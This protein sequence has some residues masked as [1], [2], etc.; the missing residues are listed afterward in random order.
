MKTTQLLS[1]LFISFLFHSC[2]FGSKNE[3]ILAD[4]QGVASIVLS[5]QSDELIKWAAT[6]LAGDL[7]SLSGQKPR[8]LIT[9]QLPEG[10]NRIII[11]GKAGD[12]LLTKNAAA[13]LEQVNG[14]WEKFMI[15]A[16]GQRLYIVGS[17]VRGTVYGIFDLAE[18]LGIS[19]WSWWADVFP[20]PGNKVSLSLPEGGIV[21]EPSVQ[22]RGIFLNDEDWGLH[23]WAAQTF[24]PETGDIGPKSYEKI[25][26]LLLR[27]KANII[28]PAMHPCTKAFYT[29]EGN[30]EMAQKYHMV[31]GTSHAEPMLRNNV[32]EWKHKERGAF[33]YFEN[34]EAVEE[35]WRERIKQVAG[36]DHRFMVTVGMR[37][38]H[39]GKMEGNATTDE[40]VAMLETI[41][42]KQRQMLEEELG[43]SASEVPQ[44]LVPYK[45][46]LDLYNAGL[47]VPDDVTLIWTDDNYGYIRRRSD[48][49]EQRRP[50]GSGVYYH[51]SYWGRPHDYLWLSTTQPALIWYEMKRAWENGAQK[52][53]IGNVGDIKPAE[54]NMEFFL[55]L[56]W[57]IDVVNHNNIDVHLKNWAA[58]EF[59]E[60]LADDIAALKQEYYRLAMLRKPEFMGWSRTEPSTATQQGEFSTR[61]INDL[62]IRLSQYHRLYQQADALKEKVAPRLRDAYFQLVEYPVKGAALMN[63]K[64]LYA[65]LAY[66]ATDKV[67]KSRYDSLARKAYAEIETLT[68][69]YNNEMSQGKWKH[70]MSSKPR[71]LAA[72]QMP[73]YHL[74][75]SASVNEK[76]E[77]AASSQ[78]IQ[79]GDYVTATGFEQYKW[80]KI[81]GLGYSAQAL[82]L[83]PLTDRSFETMQP[84]VTYRFTIDEPGA[85]ELELRCLPTHANNFDHQLSIAVENN[86]EQTFKLNTRGRSE[87]WKQN[88]LRNHSRIFYPMNFDSAGEKEVR[89]SVNQTGIVIDQLAVRLAGSERQ[90]MLPLK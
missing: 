58:R 66:E 46:V 6:E 16:V 29:I 11:I 76:V 67:S 12:E 14:A 68:N 61:G 21:Q 1:I 49:K 17:D 23:P 85:Y 36:G 73:D 42:D 47:N 9:D 32:D 89:L 45:E 13:E 38:V 26:Q 88:V 81:Q 71:K 4:K 10:E 72:Y 31:I 65:Q 33:N 43:L 59:G 34:S 35:Y 90:Y 69:Y 7:E 25:F 83:L 41:F 19:P 3:L 18:Q 62:E 50:G 24:E 52:V 79:A 60:K 30:M 86:Q 54:Y 5:P 57:N 74:E 80:K 78:F 37:G 20:E 75:Q 22:Y 51:L 84:S 48:A 56:A 82:T 28:W 87:A 64:F 8:L 70:M 39:D 27:L 63:D 53:W 15:N 2:N 44:A 77:S 40:K 55:D